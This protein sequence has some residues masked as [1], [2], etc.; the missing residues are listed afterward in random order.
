MSNENRL[1]E[2]LE[3]ISQNEKYRGCVFHGPGF[4]FIVVNGKIWEMTDNSEGYYPEIVSGPTVEEKECLTSMMDSL[5]FDEDFFRD[6][7]DDCFDFDE[8]EAEE[9]FEGNDDEDSLKIFRKLKRKVASGKTPF[10]SMEEL[11]SALMRYELDGDT[12][13]YEWEG[14]FIEFYDNIRD[15]GECRGYYDSLSDGDWIEILEGIEWRVVT[16]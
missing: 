8:E 16:A 15:C 9:Y 4:Y 7:L 12:L 3:S 1:N 13:Y 2:L 11:V 5:G 6:Y 14:E 10:A